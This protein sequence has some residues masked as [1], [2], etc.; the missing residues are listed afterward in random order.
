MQLIWL[1]VNFW[2]Q[3]LMKGW[4][5]IDRL[6]VLPALLS[7]RIAERYVLRGLW[8]GAGDLHND[9]YEVVE[10]PRE[11]RTLAPGSC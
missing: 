4:E 3:H 7:T 6:V 10:A 2:Y 8:G 5:A 11:G 9:I 1:V